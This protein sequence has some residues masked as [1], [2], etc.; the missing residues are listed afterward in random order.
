MGIPDTQ[1]GSIIT[2]NSNEFTRICRELY[3]LSE[4]VSIETN[5][6]YVKFTVNGEIFGGSI[7]IEASQMEDN[8]DATYLNVNLG[9][10]NF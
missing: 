1:Y 9:L 5:K 3:Q 10:N 6:N 2:M 7:K 8:E 4:T